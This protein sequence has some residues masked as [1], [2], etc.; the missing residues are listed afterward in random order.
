MQLNNGKYSI[1]QNAMLY[2]FVDERLLPTSSS[3][4]LTMTS[5]QKRAKWKTEVI[6]KINEILSDFR[7][8]E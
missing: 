4:V 7:Q 2:L 8:R 3:S 1:S 5:P 6:A